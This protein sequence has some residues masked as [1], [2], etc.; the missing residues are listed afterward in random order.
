[1]L[2]RSDHRQTSLYSSIKAI[3]FYCLVDAPAQLS[4][5]LQDD[6]TSRNMTN[7]SLIIEHRLLNLFRVELQA[8]FYRSHQLVTQTFHSDAAIIV[9]LCLSN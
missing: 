8:K 5:A 9:L 3:P 6:G 7:L 1:M 4:N 2:Q